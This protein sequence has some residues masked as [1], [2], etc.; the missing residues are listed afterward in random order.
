VGG[1]AISGVGYVCGGIEGGNLI[2]RVEM[3]G[4]DT[5]INTFKRCPFLSV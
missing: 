2:F 3:V 4:K 5:N 1:G